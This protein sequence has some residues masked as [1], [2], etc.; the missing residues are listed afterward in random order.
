ME[1]YIVCKINTGKALH[2]AKAY[3]TPSGV[4]GYDISCGS[5]NSGYK[6]RIHK[7]NLEATK[8]NITCKKCLA[9]LEEKTSEKTEEEK[10]KAELKRAFENRESFY[11][12]K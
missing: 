11:L 4:K 5:N 3:E 1:K 8:E 9:K 7:I 2:I 12:K 10:I 6:S